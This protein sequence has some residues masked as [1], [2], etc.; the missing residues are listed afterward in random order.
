STYSDLLQAKREQVLNKNW[1]S[2]LWFRFLQYL[3]TYQGYNYSGK[4]DA[5]LHQ[6][7]Y[8]PPGILSEKSPAP[9]PVEPIKYN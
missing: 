6:R 3:G 5:Q 7:F 2:I 9:R 8:Y 1:Q 4:I